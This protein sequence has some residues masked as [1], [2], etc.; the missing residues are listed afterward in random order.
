LNFWRGRRAERMRLGHRFLRLEALPKARPGRQRSEAALEEHRVGYLPGY[1]QRVRSLVRLCREAGIEPVLITQPALYGPTVDDVT[2][3]DLRFVEVDPEDG[4][5]GNLAWRILE[6]YND[7]LR[8]EGPDLD[9]LVVDLGRGLPK[10]SRLFY[11]F[12]HLTNEGAEA[13]A[14]FIAGELCP[15][16]ARRYPAYRAGDCPAPHAPDVQP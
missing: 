4:T 2:G 7:V 11:D 10:S 9:V 16:L 13:A 6:L 5:N 12:L 14:G 15:L 3:V 1:R 8:E